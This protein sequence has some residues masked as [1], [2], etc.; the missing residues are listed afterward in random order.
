[1]KYW[2]I[3]RK[4]SFVRCTYGSSSIV[5][6]NKNPMQTAK[7]AGRFLSCSSMRSGKLSSP[8]TFFALR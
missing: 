1:M 7:R 2:K 3:I 5:K 4:T 8:S 6:Q